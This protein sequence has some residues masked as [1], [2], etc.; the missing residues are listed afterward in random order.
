MRLRT[1]G[2]QAG[3]TLIESLI[4]LVIAVLGILGVLAMQMRTLA[5]ARTSVHRAQAIRLIEDFSERTRTHPNSLAV[6]AQYN[7]PWRNGGSDLALPAAPDC[8]RSDCS[9]QD[10]SLHDMGQWMASV[11]QSLPGSSVRISPLNED[12]DPRQ[13][14]VA[15]G[16]RENQ[17]PGRADRDQ[18]QDRAS[19][20]P[21]GRTCHFQHISLSG[22]CVPYFAGGP[23]R[24]FCP[25]P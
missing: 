21:A 6:I 5:D 10:R 14:V 20:C 3:V 2:R 8:S 25:G 12:G 19:G 9:P 11:H 17:M 4:A 23:V 22:R 15:I 1:P 18:D 13:L 7:L 24:F 16:W